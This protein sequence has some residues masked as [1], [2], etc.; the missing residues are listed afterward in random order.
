M[1]LYFY[2]LGSAIIISLISFVGVIAL[3]MNPE[4]LKKITVFLVSLSAGT[5][6]GDSFFHLMPEIIEENPEGLNIW[7][8]LIGGII[9]FFILEKIL[10]WRHCH[11]HTSEEHPHH[12]GAMN[13]IGDGL[14]NFIDGFVIAGSFLVSVPL[15][16]A[17][18]VA[19][20][21]HEIP[22]EIADFG[23][24]IYA[25]HT[26]ARAL[27]FNFLSGGIAIIGAVLA[28]AIGMKF[29]NFINFII[30]FTAGG[31]IYIAMT[32]LIPELHKET[33]ISKSLAQL[34]MILIGIALM[35]LLKFIFE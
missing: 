15:G 18:T 13:L 6:L 3:A 23:V 27:L 20:I 8:W 28:L 35:L 5:L 16:I 22:Q 26:K 11:I 34:I 25:G 24:L 33:K 29:D 21:A 2:V 7:F 31:F 19:V 9:I 10:Y 17:T 1:T 12:L 30:P 14:H 4:K 32:D